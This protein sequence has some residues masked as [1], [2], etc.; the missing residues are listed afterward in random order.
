MFERTSATTRTVVSGDEGTG[1]VVYLRQEKVEVVEEFVLH[2][3]DVGDG[4]LAED[5]GRVVIVGASMLDE[6]QAWAHRCF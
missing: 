6:Q 5:E 1:F 3:G 2:H 4:R